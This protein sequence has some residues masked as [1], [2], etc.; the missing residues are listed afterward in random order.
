MLV[1]VVVVVC[2]CVCV[3]VSDPCAPGTVLRCVVVGRD[4]C[5]APISGTYK[6]ATLL[7][8]LLLLLLVVLLLLVAYL[9][10]FLTKVQ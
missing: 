7:L 2:V 9:L 6:G 3:C 5:R 1:V 10:F 8:L 4:R